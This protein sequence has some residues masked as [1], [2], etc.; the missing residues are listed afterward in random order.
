L[1]KNDI[2]LILIAA[3]FFYFFSKMKDKQPKQIFIKE[4][5]PQ[6]NGILENTF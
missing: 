4:E 5:V 6:V 2:Y 3:T 1:K